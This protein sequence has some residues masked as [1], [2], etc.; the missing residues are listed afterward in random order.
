MIIKSNIR[1]NI[2]NI[3]GLIKKI[4]GKKIKLKHCFKDIEDNK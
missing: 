4:K 1:K 3:I 2:P